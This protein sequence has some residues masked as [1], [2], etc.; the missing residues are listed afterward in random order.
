MTLG[1]AMTEAEAAYLLSPAS[2][3]TVRVPPKWGTRSVTVETKISVENERGETIWLD[4]HISTRVPWKYSVQLRWGNEPVRRLDVRGTHRNPRGGKHWRNETHKHRWTDAHRMNLA[5]S[6]KDLADTTAK[7][8][9][10]EEY[11]LTFEAFCKECGIVLA[12]SYR[13]VE[14]VFGPQASRL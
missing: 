4:M 12:P 2:R 8:V 9:T 14:P 6:P 3:L 13:W 10:P 5:Y 1:G 11:R 7:A